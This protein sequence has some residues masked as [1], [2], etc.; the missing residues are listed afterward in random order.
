MTLNLLLPK[1]PQVYEAD[2]TPK[3]HQIGATAVWNVDKSQIHYL[4]KM[5][6]TSWRMYGSRRWLMKTFAL[7]LLDLFEASLQVNETKVWRSHI[8]MGHSFLVIFNICNR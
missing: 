2:R 8:C 6:T 7:E 3:E 1:K 5:L 4:N